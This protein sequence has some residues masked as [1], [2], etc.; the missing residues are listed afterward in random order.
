MHTKSLIAS[1]PAAV[2]RFIAIAIATSLPFFFLIMPMLVK[3]PEWGIIHT[4][5]YLATAVG[6]IMLLRWLHQQTARIQNDRRERAWVLADAIDTEIDSIHIHQRAGKHMPLAL[7][8]GLERA[9][10]DSSRLKSSYVTTEEEVLAIGR[11]AQSVI[12]ELR[13]LSERKLTAEDL[14]TYT[15]ALSEQLMQVEQSHASKVAE[16]AANIEEWRRQIAAGLAQ[17]EEERAQLS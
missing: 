14:D 2:L 16:L 9:S 17:I 4:G 5:I 7:A 12:D 8:D 15:A 10:S 13:S 6:F 11:E 3:T 1:I